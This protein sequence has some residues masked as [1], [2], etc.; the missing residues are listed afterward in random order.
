VSTGPDLNKKREFD[1][2]GG[3]ARGKNPRGTRALRAC[4]TRDKPLAP[5]APPGPPWVIPL[6]LLVTSR[7]RYPILPIS[8]RGCRHWPKALGKSPQAWCWRA[9]PGGQ[10]RKHH[11]WPSSLRT[12]S[13]LGRNGAKKKKSLMLRNTPRR[14]AGRDRPTVRQRPHGVTCSVNRRHSVPQ[15]ASGFGNAAVET[16]E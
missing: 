10:S 4:A 9:P 1:H 2:G 14:I 5:P 8:M 16:R 13:W 3:T 7:H 6:G 12:R 11:S 15:E